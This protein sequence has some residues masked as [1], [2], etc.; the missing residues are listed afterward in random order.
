MTPLEACAKIEEAL[1]ELHPE[2][3]DHWDLSYTKD[4]TDD[5]HID[6]YRESLT[7]T[8]DHF[9][10]EGPTAAH[11]VSTPENAILAWCGNSP[12]AASRAKYIAWC[13][14]R[15]LQLLI[16]RIR[17]LEDVLSYHSE[18]GKLHD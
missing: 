17:E 4:H 3:L 6:N 5:E 7:K 9:A 11:F 8:R 12:T 16:A 2:T 15:N 10:L 13:N 1:N 18:E 14:P